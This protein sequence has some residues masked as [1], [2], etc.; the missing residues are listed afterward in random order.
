MESIEYSSYRGSYSA[1]QLDQEV[2]ANTS[3]ADEDEDAEDRSGKTRHRKSALVPHG[4]RQDS[5]ETLS[6]KSSNNI[7]INNTYLS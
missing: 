2:D 1:D 4:C 5:L 6:L 7:D 3:G